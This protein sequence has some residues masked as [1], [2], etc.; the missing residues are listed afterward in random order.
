[1]VMHVSHCE[2]ESILHVCIVHMAYME[3][4][5]DSLC[6]LPLVSQYDS[7]TMLKLRLMIC[8]S[9]FMQLCNGTAQ[10]GAVPLGK[11][12]INIDL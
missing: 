6:I 5:Q 11:V 9:S 1:M 10:P 8:C 12:K 4:E 3:L 7:V 2:I